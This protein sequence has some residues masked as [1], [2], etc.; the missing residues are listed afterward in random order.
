MLTDKLKKILDV[1][2]AIR[3][4]IMEKGVSCPDDT[5]LERYPDRI[6]RISAGTGSGIESSLCFC[7]LEEVLADRQIECR[8]NGFRSSGLIRYY[9]GA[10]NYPLITFYAGAERVNIVAEE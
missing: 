9:E 4:A 6:R 7:R 2:E 10:E 5:A 8:A 3:Q 1:K